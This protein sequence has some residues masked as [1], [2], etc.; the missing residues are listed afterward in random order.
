MEEQRFM[1]IGN[2]K[3]QYALLGST[4]LQ[5]NQ[6]TLDHDSAASSDPPITA[7][8]I[9]KNIFQEYQ[10]VYNLLAYTQVVL[11]QV[12]EKRY[13]ADVRHLAVFHRHLLRQPQRV[14][15]FIH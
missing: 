11:Q 12:R 5:T 1:N 6:Y 7:K 4:I 15:D 10:K 8:T 13:P 2:K 3:N 14:I 9:P